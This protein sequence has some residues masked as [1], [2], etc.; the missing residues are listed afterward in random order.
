MK[1]I[2]DGAGEARIVSAAG[3]T[4]R[5]L[6]P[7]PGCSFSY[8]DTLSTLVCRG[9]AAVDGWWDWRFSVDLETGAMERIGPAY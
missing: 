8:A 6:T 4:L 9:E 1:L 7:P 5:T 2:V 3:D